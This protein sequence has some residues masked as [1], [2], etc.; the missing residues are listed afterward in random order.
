MANDPQHPQDK[1]QQPARAPAVG[2]GRE[3]LRS[4]VRPPVPVDNPANPAPAIPVPVAPRPPEPNPAASS[5]IALGAIRQKMEAIAD[6]FA[7]GKLN[8]DQ[9]YALHRRYSEQRA[10]IEK[11][12]ERNPDTD[13]WK[14]VIG[15]PGQTGFLRTHFAARTLYFVVY[16]NGERLPLINAGSE[17]PD[18]SMID[19]VIAPIWRMSNRPKQGLGRKPIGEQKWLL[20]ASGAYATTIVVWSTEPSLGQARL[21]RDLHADFE[22]ANQAAL[23]RGW[24]APDKMVF[25][26]RALL[27]TNG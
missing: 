6:E 9:F 5:L 12:V 4:P 23:A 20:L 15:T 3:T 21:V 27:Q 10:I 19:S 11:L 7:R 26:Q 18:Y 1:S 24:I 14:Q 25:P 13:A 2:D 8:R 17:Q 22:R 16:R